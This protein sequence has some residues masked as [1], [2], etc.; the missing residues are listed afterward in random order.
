MPSSFQSLF[1]SLSSPTPS[2]LSPTSVLR[3][4]EQHHQPVA[5]APSRSLSE[6]SSTSSPLWMLSAGHDD[7]NNNNE[8]EDEEDGWTPVEE[9]SNE[10]WGERDEGDE[11]EA[12][13]ERAQT[14]TPF[15]W[16]NR[17]CGEWRR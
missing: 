6:P 2:S 16:M 11:E 10:T 3:I 7:N 14:R 13:A 17:S 5:W 12:E 15:S 1:P 9:S 8:D 4:T